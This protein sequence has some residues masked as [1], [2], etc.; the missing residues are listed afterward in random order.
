MID[1][2]KEIFLKSCADMLQRLE[3]YVKTSAAGGVRKD[4]QMAKSDLEK[5][6]G[7]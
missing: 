6:L 2:E 7:K 1:A 4:V 5:I 3:I